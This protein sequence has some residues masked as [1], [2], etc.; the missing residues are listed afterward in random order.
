MQNLRAQHMAAESSPAYAKITDVDLK[1][2]K[3][4]YDRFLGI[5]KAEEGLGKGCFIPNKVPRRDGYVRFAVPAGSAKSAFGPD[6]PEKE[7]TFYLHHLAWY[8]TGHKMP[9]PVTE[10][11]SHL[12]GDPRCFNIAHLTVES[13][14]ANNARK[15][16]LPAV[17]CPFGCA[18]AFWIC[19]H[20]P[21][22]I[23][24]LELAAELAEELL[25]PSA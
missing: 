8:V 10:H 16:C 21:K 18:K 1:F 11:L 22:C 23:P 5:L 2:A 17:R 20:E 6:A 24:T 3:K 9:T 25:P 14:A 4:H 12:C 19:R 7:R 13:P 15:G